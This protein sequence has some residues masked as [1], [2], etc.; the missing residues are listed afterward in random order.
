MNEGDF[1]IVVGIDRYPFLKSL[2]GPVK[3][4]RAFRNWVVDGAEVPRE[5]VHLITSSGK[6]PPRPILDQI[7]DAYMAIFKQAKAGAA[8]RL[9]VYFAGHGCSKEAR[10]LALI[11]ANADLKTLNRSLNARDYHRDLATLATFPEQIFFYD[12][13]RN[14]DRRVLGRPP[15]FTEE[16]PGAQAAGVVQFVLYGAAFT[17]YA[18]ERKQIYSTKRGLFTRALLDGLK[19]GAASPEAGDW[20][21]RGHRLVEFVDARLKQLA[22][23]ESVRQDIGKEEVGAIRDLVFAKGVKPWLQDVAVTTQIPGGDI[24]VLLGDGYAEMERKPNRGGPIKFRLIP[25]SYVFRHEPSNAKEIGQVKPRE[26]LQVE[27]KGA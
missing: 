9:Y 27:V 23:Q 11:M 10:H 20:L 25:G 13:C 16:E 1:A 5:N 22:D 21:V 2:E 18:N 6:D 24:V 8:R 26:K 3:D 15:A 12:C 7:D 19:G 14:Y 17:Q 4:A